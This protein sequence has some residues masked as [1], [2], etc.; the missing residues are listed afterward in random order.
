M[1]K[2]VKI[3]FVKDEINENKKKMKVADFRNGRFVFTGMKLL[4]K[5]K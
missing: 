4:N 2:L 3:E 5:V 1:K